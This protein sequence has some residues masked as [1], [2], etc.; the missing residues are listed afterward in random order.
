MITGGFGSDGSESGGVGDV[1]LAML[2]SA[3]VGVHCIADMRVLIVEDVRETII[4]EAAAV[5]DFFPEPVVGRR[6][7]HSNPDA[8]VEIN[9]EEGKHG[10]G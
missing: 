1:V 5:V 4:V 6:L 3:R 8:E 9:F 2:G 10:G 7:T